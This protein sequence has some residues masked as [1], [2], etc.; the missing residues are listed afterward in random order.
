[1]PFLLVA[2]FILSGAAGLIYE[3]IWSRYLSLFV[4]HSADAQVI[5]LVIYLGGMSLGA[6]VA[7][8]WS[9]RI[10][11]PLIGYAAVEIAVG[12]IGIFFDDIFRGVTAVAY[13][14]VFPALAGG[15][16]LV[17]VKWMLAGLLILPQSI[18]LGTTF[19][20]MSA[21]YLRLASRDGGANSGRALSV[22]YFA[23]SI[24]AAVGVLVA[25]F[26]LIGLAGLP[27]TLLTAAIINVLVGLAVFGAVRLTTERPRETGPET[28]VP[29]VAPERSPPRIPVHADL[30]FLWRVLLIVS[31][32]TALSSFV[33][34]IS[35]V[36][37]LSL[38]L[39]SA[40][41]SFE[42]MLSA[43]ILGLSLGAF[44]VRTHADRFRDP[45]R[46]LGVTQW[47]MGA[48][49]IFTLFA[50][51]ASFGWMASL[52]QGLDQNEDGYRFF[53]IAK[54]GIA[55][56]VMLPATFC[57]G[58]T[59]PLITRTLLGAGSGERA[60]GA[61]YSINTLGS[62]VG[63]ALAA[64]LL[65]PLIGLKALLITGGAIDMVLGVWLLAIAGRTSAQTQ[66]FAIG[67]AGA[68]V[69]VVFSAAM[70]V[71]FD[72]GILISGVYR[73]GRV[74]KPGARNVVFYRDGRTAT[75][76]VRKSDDGSYSLA[77]NGKP[78]ASLSATWFEPM[79]DTTTI[80]RIDGDESTQVLLPLITLA[81]APFA[82]EG[83][84]IGNGSGMS[85]HFLL[86][87]P[88]LER[89]VTIDIEPEMINGSHTFYPVNR[90]V[91]DDPRAQYVHDDAKSYFAAANRKFDL[92]LS[93]PSNPWVSGVSGLF[94]DEFYQRIHGY[95]TPD[96]VF[97][98]WLHL[99]EIDDNLVLSVI[100]AL[101]RNFASYDIYLA[102]DVD[103]LIV[104]S[105][106][107]HLKAPDWS[108]FQLPLI[109]K[110]LAH[111]RP[112]TG[113][114]IERAHLVSR[115]ALAPILDSSK[116]VNSDFYPVLD[117]LTERT[118]YM[119]EYAKGFSGLNDSRFDV[120]AA[121]LGQRILPLKAME[122][123]L[124]IARVN[125]LV[126]GARLRSGGKPDPLAGE[127]DKDF[128]E[129]AER[130]QTL[131]DL[132][133]AGHP[134]ADWLS[135]FKLVLDVEADRHDGT[136]G[137]ADEPWYANV[138]RF[139]ERQ[140]A[141]SG[142]RSA[143][144]FMHAVAAYDWPMAAEEVDSLLR[145]RAEGISWLNNDLFREAA[146]VAL[147][148]T[149]H[150]LRARA[151][152]DKMAEYSSRKAGDLRVRMLDAHIAR[153]ERAKDLRVRSTET[154]PADGGKRKAES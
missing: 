98:Q 106:Q 89:L 17:I 90:R 150:V 67:V 123:V 68:T 28:G 143:L 80:V 71:H 114:T 83:A 59:L 38:V 60:I 19:P 147:L 82:K 55:L 36:R 141:P 101:H 153:R 53:T 77:T 149:N 125:E 61:V 50:Y 74:P 14:T 137:W 100:N 54:Y 76:S 112:I 135:F 1:M 130:A 129:A 128:R 22:L 66:R 47:A 105:N 124:D 73:Y 107:P 49:A 62:I 127:G 10:R 97:G 46:A 81:H 131:N 44:W 24:G 121:L 99:Y 91:F 37:M 41:H 56:A 140:R 27:G 5:V 148:H 33:Y 152:F 21:G 29:V 134:P 58:V 85:S 20:L 12:L 39:G 78:D 43:F 144:R 103:I 70:N 154:R 31:F 94:T 109:A 136:M 51:L 151:T 86:G 26:F 42:I 4:G 142:C 133:A 32:G 104:A 92:I 146:V 2:V 117:L 93:E 95:L 8:R 64:L 87:S 11:Q 115:A 3:S 126:L 120:G 118:R 108:V 79:T 119:K 102:A 145:A 84:V 52:L 9:E 69:L 45:L 15:A 25:G 111:F 110:D 30:P 75:V 6:A 63:A 40:T 88:R 18:L 138:T 116:V 72:R 13:S 132:I 65:L 16:A 48:L 35:W 7:A 23:N 139:L 122:S 34:E 96:G 57:A 113:E